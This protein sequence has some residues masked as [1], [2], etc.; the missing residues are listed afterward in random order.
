MQLLAHYGILGGGD[1][2]G[3]ELK[4]GYNHLLLAKDAYHRHLQAQG[5]YK[6]HENDGRTWLYN[7]LFSYLK[8]HDYLDKLNNNNLFKEYVS[9]MIEN[10]ALN[11]KKKFP[12]DFEKLKTVTDEQS[13][14]LT[15]MTII[16]RKK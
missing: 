16:Y 14:I 11:F 6:H 4:N 8:P 5:E 15:G 12:Q 3:G 7:D 2:I 13:L 1:H 9:G 10:R